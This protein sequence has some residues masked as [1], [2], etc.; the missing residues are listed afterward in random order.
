M[1]QV[2]EVLRCAQDDKSLKSCERFRSVL[3]RR[4]K[5]WK[6]GPRAAFYCVIHRRTVVLGLRSWK[7]R[8]VLEVVLQN[9]C[10]ERGAQG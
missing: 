3:K 7:V 5:K 4:E 2:A 9:P 1:V 8:A 6:G 10:S